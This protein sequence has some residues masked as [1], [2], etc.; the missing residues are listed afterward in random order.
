MLLERLRH[1]SA[2]HC[3]WQRAEPGAGGSHCESAGKLRGGGGRWALSCSFTA[4]DGV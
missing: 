4:G 1:G 3:S 2:T